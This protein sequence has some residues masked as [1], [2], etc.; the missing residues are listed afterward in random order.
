MELTF[1]T[2][3]EAVLDAFPATPCRV[4]AIAR[5]G[6]DAYVVLDTGL[7]GQPYLNGICVERRGG[8]WVVGSS[9]NGGGWTLTDS[10]RELGT[11]TAW[12]E[13]PE[14]TER[15]RVV[16]GGEAKEA[17]VAGGVYLVAW[18]RVPYRDE[19]PRVDAFKIHG[20]W[21]PGPPTVDRPRERSR[22]PKR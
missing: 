3:E 20:R 13:A 5:E 2:P 10:E 16:F 19:L 21:V 9:G 15:V 1:D 11:A 18:W 4:A 12:G 14:G 22:R 6:D 7:L 8:G 17:P